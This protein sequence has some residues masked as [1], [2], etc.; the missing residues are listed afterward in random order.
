MI[1]LDNGFKDIFHYPQK[2]LQPFGT[3]KV[4]K[5]LSYDTDF[6]TLVNKGLQRFIS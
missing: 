5:L 3:I 6:K 4:S 1:I 2:N